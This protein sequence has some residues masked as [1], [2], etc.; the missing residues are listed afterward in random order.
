MTLNERRGMPIWKRL[1]F[2]LLA[3]LILAV[4]IALVA[5]FFI[6]VIGAE[7]YLYGSI[8]GLILL[9]IQLLG[10]F[11]SFYVSRLDMSTNY[12]TLWVFLIILIPY[13]F[14]IIYFLNSTSRSYSKKKREK[15]FKAMKKYRTSNEYDLNDL[16]KVDKNIINILGDDLY[17]PVYRNTKYVFFSDIEDKF[18]DM[19]EEMS[20]AKHYILIESFILRSG[21]LMDKVIDVLTKKGNEGVKIYILYDTVGSIGISRRLIR[22]LEHIKNCQINNYEPL[23]FS[24][25]LLVNYRDH[26]KITVIDG[27]IAYCGGDNFSDEYIHK[28]TRFGYWRDNC[29]KY[30]GEAVNTFVYLFSSMWYVSTQEELKLDYKPDYKEINYDIRNVIIPFGD[31]PSNSVDTSYNLFVSLFMNAQEKIYISTPYF[32]IDDQ[33]INLLWMKAKSG[34]DVR[35]LMPGI[36]D[37][38]IVY[39]MGEANYRKLLLA[40]VKI[41]EYKDGFNHAKNII[42][43]NKY[44]FIGTINMDYRSLFLHYE[45]GAL[46]MYDPEINKMEDDFI[47]S[48]DSS[49]LFTYKDYK[50]RKWYKKFIAFVLN[51]FGPFF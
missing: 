51:I 46:I 13:V 28:V 39:W 14:I 3:I 15:I 2:I 9:A 27:V 41:Y 4:N 35:I 34:V 21:Y 37:K 1:F 8:T 50:K 19:L 5:V 44:A 33:M 36:P 31:G 30:I 43:D 26:R 20:K 45:C 6:F 22:R 49:P 29:G 18:I 10:V 25:N 40:G 32:I 16:S 48:C 7:G 24:I 23:G 11:F 12:K 47:K 38:K 17:A 42:I